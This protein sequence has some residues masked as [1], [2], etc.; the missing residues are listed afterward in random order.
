MTGFKDV[1]RLRD[2]TGYEL[3]LAPFES[4]L[5]VSFVETDGVVTQVALRVNRVR[6]RESR[7]RFIV[8]ERGVELLI[9][10]PSSNP[11]ADW[12]RDS[13]TF[14]EPVVD[15]EVILR[16]NVPLAHEDA[17]KRRWEDDC[18]RPGTSRFP[19]DNA[20]RRAQNA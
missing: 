4:V 9:W 20:D 18:Y 16:S 3:R 13:M 17:A 1:A 15:D 10:V 19:M 6:G 5:S 8:T 11:W 7:G 14:W 2:L 12:S